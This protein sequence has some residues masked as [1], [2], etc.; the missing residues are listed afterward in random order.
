MFYNLSAHVRR[1][2]HAPGVA[3]IGSVNVHP[4]KA[5]RK[6]RRFRLS[7]LAFIVEDRFD[8]KVNLALITNCKCVNFRVAELIEKIT[9]FGRRQLR[10]FLNREA[11][12]FSFA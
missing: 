3:Q 8:L 11:Q 1:N 6:N 5:A 4:Y 9:Y 2:A 12:I 7:A 10:A